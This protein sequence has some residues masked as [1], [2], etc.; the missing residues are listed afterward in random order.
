MIILSTK[1]VRCVLYQCTM[2][3]EFDLSAS[4]IFL[5]HLYELDEESLTCTSDFSLRIHSL[6]SCLV[7]GHI[8]D[9]Y[10]HRAMSI[11]F[12]MGQIEKDI[13]I[14]ILSCPMTIKDIYYI[15]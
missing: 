11:K 9:Y 4:F 14:M 2:Y 13:I 12:Q 6:S 10:L 1:L 15:M 8:P 5:V 7:Y 3:I